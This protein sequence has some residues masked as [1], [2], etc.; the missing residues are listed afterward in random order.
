MFVRSKL[1][2]FIVFL[3]L[4]CFCFAQVSIPS[5]EEEQKKLAEKLFEQEEY[6]QAFKLYSTLLAHYPKDPKFNYRIGVCIL[7]VGDEKGERKNAIRYL[8]IA[9]QKF[10]ELDKE[11]FFYLGKAYHVNYD[12]DD[13]I[14]HYNEY[15]SIASASSI[16]KLKVDHEIQMAR[17]G[18]L[19][20]SKFPNVDVIEKKR[21]PSGDYFRSYQP[22]FYGGNLISKPE[23]FKLNADKKRKDK[24]ILFQSKD[25]SLVLFSSYGENG[26]NGK[27]IYIAK[28]QPDGEFGKPFPVS[29]NI[30]TEF[31]EDYPYLHPNGKKLYFCSKG[32]NSIG[33]YDI[34]SSEW[35]EDLNDWGK[36]VNMQFPINT[37][38]DDIQYVT[39]STEKFAIFSS[40]RLSENGKIDVYKI[41]IERR[42]VSMG[43]VTG[44]IIKNENSKGPSVIT[45]KDLQ[46]G[47]TFGPFK[48]DINGKYNFE[49]PNG[50][51][52][53]FTVESQDTPVQSE[54]V[55]IPVNYDHSP[56]K[57]LITYENNKMIIKNYFGEQIDEHAYKSMK[58]LLL[59]KMKMDIGP[60]NSISIAQNP[61]NTNSDTTNNTKKT[62]EKDS[63]FNKEE[64]IKNQNN[65]GIKKNLSNNE[66]SDI[67]VSDLE[68]LKKETEELRQQK[69]TSAKMLFNLKE[70]IDK[71]EARID[72]LN[73]NALNNENNSD[74]LNDEKKEL[75]ELK[76]LYNRANIIHN[77]LITDYNNKESEKKLQEK[78]VSVMCEIKKNPKKKEMEKL[79]LE[80]EEE[81]RKHQ[82]SSKDL[83]H[84]DIIDVTQVEIEQ[85]EK[86]LNEYKKQQK[87]ITTE[88]ELSKNEVSEKKNELNK[89]SD[90]SIKESIQAEIDNLESEKS[91]SEKKLNETNLKITKQEQE[92]EKLKN[93]NDFALNIINQSK[94]GNTDPD[95]LIKK[96]SSNAN[97]NK[98]ENGDTTLNKG[99]EKHYDSEITFRKKIE[100]LKS[101][102]IPRSNLTD[103]QQ[104][105]K[106]LIDLKKL[107][108][109]KI[110]DINNLNN[111]SNKNTNNE[112]TD[113]FSSELRKELNE[114]NDKLDLIQ[115]SKS[116]QISKKEIILNKGNDLNNNK[117]DSAQASDKKITSTFNEL[118]I[119]E[120]EIISRLTPVNNSDTTEII[121]NINNYESYNRVIDELVNLLEDSIKRSGSKKEKEK[122]KKSRAEKLNKKTEITSIIT[123]YKKILSENSVKQI[124]LNEKTNNQSISDTTQARPT[125][126]TYENSFEENGHLL[127]FYTP[128]N[129]T[130]KVANQSKAASQL[131]FNKIYQ[132]ELEL[133]HRLNNLKE[134]TDSVRT[135]KEVDSKKSEIEKIKQLAK[136]NRTEAKNSTSDKRKKLIAEAEKLEKDAD[137]ISLK[138]KEDAIKSDME[139]IK[140][141]EIL[142]K[143]L[144]LSIPETEK[145]SLV[146]FNVGMS[147][148]RELIQSMHSYHSESENKSS[149]DARTE[150]LTMAEESGRAAIEKQQQIINSLFIEINKNKQGSNIR[151]TS[152]TEIEKML[153]EKR[154]EKFN[155]LLDLSKSNES[156]F[157]SL[158]NKVS[159]SRKKSREKGN[160][161][162]AN[163]ISNAE[164]LFNSAQG[165]SKELLKKDELTYNF[166]QI[167][168]ILHKQEVALMLLNKA[169]IFYEN[170]NPEQYGEDYNNIKAE[171]STGNA[172]RLLAQIKNDSDERKS[173]KR[174]NNLDEKLMSDST[175]TSIRNQTINKNQT[176]SSD[177]KTENSNKNILDSAKLSTVK[178]N[179][180]DNLSDSQKVKSNVSDSSINQMISARTN[181]DT[182]NKENKIKTEKNSSNNAVNNNSINQ[183][184]GTGN[185]EVIQNKSN[186]KQNANPDSASAKTDT[187]SNKNIDSNN[188]IKSDENITIDTNN[189]P[190]SEVQPAKTT[191]SSVTLNNATKERT[192]TSNIKS[193][194]TNGIKVSSSDAYSDN[195]PIPIDNK[196]PSGIIFTVQVGA[197][198]T[199]VPN[200]TFK[201]IDPIYGTKT[202]TGFIRYQAGLFEKYNEANAAKNDLKKLGFKDAFVAVYKNNQRID[203]ADA[204]KELN[205]STEEDNNTSAGI[206]TG[207][208]VPDGSKIIPENITSVNQQPVV[209]YT[210]IEKITGLF[211]TIQVGLFSGNPKPEQLYNLQPIQREAYNGSNYRFL[212]GIYNKL[213]KVRQDAVKV[214]QIG[215]SDAFICA[216]QNGKRVK[217][218]EIKNKENDVNFVFARE[219]PIVFKSNSINNSNNLIPDTNGVIKKAN[220][221]TTAIFSNGVSKD[222]VPTNENG[223]KL[224]NE[225]ITYKIQIGAYSKNVPNSVSDTWLKI[226]T[227]PVRYYSNQ[228]NLI[229]YTIGSFGDFQ[230]AKKFLFEIK[231]LGVLDAFITVFKNGNRL[232]GEQATQYTR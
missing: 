155:V 121:K 22:S 59:E 227:W 191:D 107:I 213:E 110:T 164:T 41:N 160:K 222:P 38:L 134:V 161:D 100:Q 149:F 19:F 113:K 25:K 86:N 167:D 58:N 224:T 206:N 63:S 28:R 8:E 75:N 146:K 223:V 34:F 117:N 73:K 98:N 29:K 33:G 172:E 47:E 106:V 157:N 203:L 99:D 15:K 26:E 16:K 102:I 185:N 229:I 78:L 124:S 139:K 182:S 71:K 123:S 2:L 111:E 145:S 4:S 136:N 57:Q 31:D 129:Y 168:T 199:P 43:W 90:K 122:L 79:L 144:L 194:S 232:Y 115:K 200:A 171:K 137:I 142:I 150:L 5:N 51:R 69:E 88:I 174:K 165:L 85:A 211:Y 159:A 105:E 138:I 133:R 183:V 228:N 186:D 179:S 61:Q 70:V 56:C 103:E 53:I 176:Q 188:K 66:L 175:Q 154:L 39:D 96:Y 231:E 187:F 132:E 94:S 170:G 91:E 74:R 220:E 214:K 207:G 130:D 135:K 104:N 1:F 32:H 141:N 11:V 92:I 76:D 13:A 225:G 112:T 101:Q 36:P 201:G 198:R 226:K 14:V 60:N 147:D 54:S 80:T 52:Y 21:L 119:K 151:D 230:N 77:N 205:I 89:E 128:I 83:K 178:K 116:E 49:I 152:V 84:D 68:D 184:Q 204:L 45:I 217:I 158:K 46:S 166:S 192:N 82:E 127:D 50:K 216:Y 169:K 208:N 6:A 7:N 210:A 177:P 120:R 81:L 24:F 97:V 215:I 209:S 95:N 114:I 35:N 212:A 64:N 87:N 20:L 40:T 12:F 62:F 48:T 131:N 42:P 37:P 65:N 202:P 148:I 196:F 108:E 218:A 109:E 126:N 153:S 190:I 3:V 163:W 221:T 180:I 55:E 44:E 140:R 23:E 195:N 93:Q 10:N 189:K 17:N 9:K 118:S 156:E 67:A 181:K 197:F 72:S 193:V 30:N 18:K 162:A 173:D 27:D 143:E 219:A 125:N